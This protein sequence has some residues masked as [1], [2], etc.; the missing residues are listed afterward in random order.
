MPGNV[1]DGKQDAMI[2]D[3]EGIVPVASDLHFRGG[4]TVDC[5][6]ACTVDAGKMRRERRFL[7]R[8]NQAPFA[9]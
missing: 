3:I 6:E 5:A 1:A 9:D 4:G 7:D 2:V 8:L